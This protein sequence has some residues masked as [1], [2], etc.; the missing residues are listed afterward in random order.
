MDDQEQDFC[1]KYDITVINHKRGY[2]VSHNRFFTN[3]KDANVITEYDRSW[4]EFLDDD[5]YTIPNYEKILVIEIPERSLDRLIDID[6]QFFTR[7]GPGS[8]RAVL[9]FLERESQAEEIRRRNP[10]V[11]TA[12]EQYSLMLHLAS[13]GQN[14]D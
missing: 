5:H 4:G 6:R 9:A 3:P 10:A 14:L 8:Q 13:N 11:Q 12:W 1:K 2:R 7:M